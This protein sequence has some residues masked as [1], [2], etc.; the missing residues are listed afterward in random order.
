MRGP[1]Y[2]SPGA[3]KRLRSFTRDTEAS[4]PL[5]PI[6]EMHARLQAAERA[7]AILAMAPDDDAGGSRNAETGEPTDGAVTDRRRRARDEGNV[8]ARSRNNKRDG[9]GYEIEDSE[10]ES[11]T[12]PADAREKVQAKL[13]YQSRKNDGPNVRADGSGSGGTGDQEMP[14][15]PSP[16]SINAANAK[17]WRRDDTNMAGEEA[18]KEMEENTAKP[19]QAGTINV[20]ARSSTTARSLDLGK[21]WGGVTTDSMR[22]GAR[23]IEGWEA[24]ARRDIAAISNKWSARR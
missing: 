2:I 6:R 5:S 7:I 15:A 4:S 11:D 16:A 3:A 21:T 12:D 23:I 14:S 20:A 13:A 10:P 18:A 17:M 19:R 22:R 8:G 1:I 24:N 9:T